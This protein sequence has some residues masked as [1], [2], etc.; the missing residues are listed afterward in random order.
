[1]FAWGDDQ[2]TDVVVAKQGIVNQTGAGE[3][4]GLLVLFGGEKEIDG[5]E[6]R[7]ENFGLALVRR[8]VISSAEDDRGGGGQGRMGEGRSNGERNALKACPNALKRE[9]SIKRSIFQL[10]I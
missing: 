7:R 5:G 6:K 1:L 3:R 2:K 10:V 9:N 4:K 8:P